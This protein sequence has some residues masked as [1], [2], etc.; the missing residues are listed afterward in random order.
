MGLEAAF[1]GIA[2]GFSGVL[3]GPFHAA[4]VIEHIDAVYDDGGSII[5]PGGTTFRACQVQIDVATQAMR[6]APNFVDTDVRVIILAATLTG[7]L[8]TEAM[9]E[10]SA[11]P[12][13]GMWSV[14]SLERD[15]AALGWIGTG[16]R[17]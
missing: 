8:N 1:A 7:S 4:R 15:P 3:G 17:G 16:R 6:Q 14:S 5:T 2:L 12:F 10:V 13:A 9:V 11:G